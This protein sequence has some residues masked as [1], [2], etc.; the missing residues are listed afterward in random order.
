LSDQHEARKYFLLNKIEQPA[1]YH[2]SSVSYYSSTPLS[3]WRSSPGI[4]SR[5][6]AAAMADS[7][8]ALSLAAAK[9]ATADTLS[10]VMIPDLFLNKKNYFNA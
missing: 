8:A 4:A 7:K 6:D 2:E 10:V 5:N 3:F 9:A 1:K